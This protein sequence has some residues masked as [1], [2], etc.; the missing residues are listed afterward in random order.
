MQ[1]IFLSEELYWMQR[2]LKQWK[3]YLVSD[4]IIKTNVKA[5]G[6]KILPMLSSCPPVTLYCSSI[7][8]SKYNSK[9]SYVLWLCLLFHL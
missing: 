6:W 9:N 2:N 3:I 1:N 8:P 7:C 4:R 5:K